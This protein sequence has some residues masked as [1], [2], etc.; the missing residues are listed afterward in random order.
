M[1]ASRI[2]FTATG[3]GGGATLAWDFGDGSTSSERA[4][5]HVYTTAGTFTVKCS[6]GHGS[7]TTN[8]TI[9]SLAGTWRGNLIDPVQGPIL[10]TLSFTQNGAVIGGTMSDVYGPGTLSGSVNTSAPLV[11][12]SIKQPQFDAFVFTAD[13]NGD[14]TVLNGV[15]NGAGFV[16]APMNITRQ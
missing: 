5:T 12:V 9:K 11:R 7:A 15:V 3:V 10:E 13:P 16:N 2:T 14:I 8:V 1:S 6:A 4:P